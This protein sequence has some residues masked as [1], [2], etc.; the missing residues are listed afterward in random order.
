MLETLTSSS[1]PSKFANT[2]QSARYRVLELEGLPEK[3]SAPVSGA[4]ELVFWRT[5]N[6]V[7]PT[8]R[9]V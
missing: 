6:V 7:V 3:V 8:K 9:A 4:G 5:S 1:L 2:V